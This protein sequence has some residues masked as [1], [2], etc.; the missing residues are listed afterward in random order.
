MIGPKLVLS[1]IY[2][3]FLI[4]LVEIW[5]MDSQLS[6]EAMKNVRENQRKDQSWSYLEWS[7]LA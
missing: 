4:Y 5:N 7:F 3:T 6:C 2:P 1:S